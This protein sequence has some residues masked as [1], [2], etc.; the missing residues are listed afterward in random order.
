MSYQLIPVDTIPANGRSHR[1]PPNFYSDI[2]K[3]FIENKYPKAELTVEGRNPDVVAQRLS[4]R[5]RD[6]EGIS[7]VSRGDKVYLINHSLNSSTNR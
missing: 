6:E 3:V 2:I 5:L 1:A 4:Y 7:V